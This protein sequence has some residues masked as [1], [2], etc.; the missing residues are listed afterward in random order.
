MSCLFALQL[1]C[2]LT[3]PFLLSCMDHIS[4]AGLPLINICL[5]CDEAG[6]SRSWL[7]CSKWKSLHRVL[8][9]Q[10]D[11]N[12]S[13]GVYLER[14]IHGPQ[15]R[16]QKPSDGY[17][18]PPLPISEIWLSQEVTSTLPVCCS[19]H[20]DLHSRFP[21]HPH[22]GSSQVCAVLSP[23]RMSMHILS[24]PPEGHALS[25]LS[26]KHSSAEPHHP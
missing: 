16:Q 11:L 14:W 26:Q 6:R 4:T 13:S 25:H 12:S 8:F 22:T 2:H 7:C 24:V 9:H 19:L 17:Y 1:L 10:D 15:R 21:K 20:F 5:D 3:C 23:S 18:S